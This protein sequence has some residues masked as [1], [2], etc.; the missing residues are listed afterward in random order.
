MAL[1]GTLRM[2][3]KN[4][5]HLTNVFNGAVGNFGQNSTHFTQTAN[6]GISTETVVQLVPS[7]PT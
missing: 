1:E 7:V 5:P 4:Q 2:Y 3:E 6:T